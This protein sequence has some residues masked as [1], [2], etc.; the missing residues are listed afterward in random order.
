MTAT[1]PNLAFDA[2]LGEGAPFAG[3]GSA[4]PH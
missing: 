2:G 4:L 1:V 3:G